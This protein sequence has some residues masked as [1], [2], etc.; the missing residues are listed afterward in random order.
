[1][2]GGDGLLRQLDDLSL[3]PFGQLLRHT[4][5]GQSSPPAFYA[6]YDQAD[7]LPVLTVRTSSGIGPLS[8]LVF[9]TPDITSVW[10]RYP[11]GDRVVAIAVYPYGEH[12]RTSGR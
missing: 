12:A 8:V 6:T 10:L 11:V 9:R 7:Q 2:R 3:V 1:M 4:F 5:P